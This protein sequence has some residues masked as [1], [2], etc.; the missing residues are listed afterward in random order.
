MAT[1]DIFIV[2]HG[3]PAKNRMTCRVPEHCEVRFYITDG[4]KL[5]AGK[6]K[7]MLEAGSIKCGDADAGTDAAC[8]IFRQREN[9][10]DM[11]LRPH[12]ISTTRSADQ[13]SFDIG[14]VKLK[15]RGIEP[16][17]LMPWSLSKLDE[18]GVDNLSLSWVMKKVLETK[19]KLANAGYEHFRFHWLCCRGPLTDPFADLW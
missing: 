6:I 17:L 2:G 4:Y 5:N 9:V 18:R 1:R 15:A 14:K 7:G 11:T 19:Q 3:G 13:G 8:E 16:Q 12:S 10:P